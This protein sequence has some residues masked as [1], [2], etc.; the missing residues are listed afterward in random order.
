MKGIWGIWSLQAKLSLCLVLTNVVLIGFSLSSLLDAVNMY[1]LAGRLAAINACSEALYLS[2]EA[3]AFERGRAKVILAEDNPVTEVN[4]LF[5]KERRRQADESLQIGLERL[6]MIEPA[7]AEHLRMKYEELKKLRDRV[8]VQAGMDYSEREEIFGDEWFKF[9]TV[10]ILEIRDVLELLSSKEPLGNFFNYSSQLQLYCIEFRIF[11]GYSGSVLTTALTQNS[12]IS[13]DKYQEFLEARAKADYLWS[14]LNN[15]IEKLKH[16]KITDNR[17]K[18]LH[19]YFNTYRPYQNTL[20]QSAMHEPVSKDSIIRLK[21]LSVPA[22]DSIFGLIEAINVEKRSHF[23][24]LKEQAAREL[25]IAIFNCFL[26]LAFSVAVFCYFR[27]RLFVP[28]Q[29]IIHS[30]QSVVKGEPTIC[31]EADAKRKDEIGWLVRGVTLLQTNIKEERRLKAKNEML[32][33]TDGLTGLYNRHRLAQE[34]DG[35]LAEADHCNVPISLIMLDIDNFKNVNDKYGH[36]VG[37]EVLKEISQ[38][39]KRLIRKADKLFRVGGEEFLILLP[40]TDIVEVAEVAEKIR[41]I[42]EEKRLLHVGQVTVS[43][44]VAE[45]YKG[46]P[47]Q[48]ALMRADDNLYQAKKHGRNRVVSSTMAAENTVWRREWESG[49]SE[50]DRQH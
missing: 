47:F 33:A 15:A 3:L 18:V 50:I 5:I 49:H 42:L 35:I 6:N 16:D 36:L 13:S 34:I 43:L 48:E 28:M 39:V 27:S 41:K 38:I 14:K 44:G 29:R 9:A 20:L 19:E 7:T 8:D 25:Q 23:A 4:Q 12:T 24:D 31:L 1:N 32:A 46:E 26:V 21:T 22:F 37:D 10:F 11:S 17:D 2:I 30:L 45:R 40:R